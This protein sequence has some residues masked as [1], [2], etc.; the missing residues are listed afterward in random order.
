MGKRS[1]QLFVLSETTDAPQDTIRYNQR[2]I[3][4]GRNA[5]PLLSFFFP[6]IATSVL[7]HSLEATS[8][9]HSEVTV[10]NSSVGAKRSGRV[11]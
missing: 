3:E 7:G 10:T 1:I 9:I 11:I 4:S 6:L 2:L 5:L 8:Q